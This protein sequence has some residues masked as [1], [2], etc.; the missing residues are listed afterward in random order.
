[1]KKKIYNKAQRLLALFFALVLV[2]SSIQLPSAAA[3]KKEGKNG[4]LVN[5]AADCDI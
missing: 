4:N 2:I 1:M 5:I 3:E